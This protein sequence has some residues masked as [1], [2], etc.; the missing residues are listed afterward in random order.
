[1]T[2][3]RLETALVNTRQKDPCMIFMQGLFIACRSAL[4]IRFRIAPLLCTRSRPRVRG[5]GFPI[6]PG[7]AENGD[8]PSR[9]AVFSRLK[10]CQST[11]TSAETSLATS[12][13]RA[14]PVSV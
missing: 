7:M 1:M 10:P 9:M 4:K 13:G 12:S 2:G 3:D 14:L 8:Y 11:P 5:A 6:A